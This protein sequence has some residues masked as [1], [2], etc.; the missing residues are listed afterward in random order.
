M[1]AGKLDRRIT[2][3]SVTWVK[4]EFGDDIEVE[5]PLATIWAFLMEQRPGEV[6]S[7]GSDQSTDQVIFQIRK[8]SD[9]NATM[10]VEY[11]T[12]RFEITGI[13]EVGRNNRLNLICERQGE[14]V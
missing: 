12:D 8:R 1:R 11:K 7:A 10:I 3:I 4:N 9:I 6:F 5:T 2:V 13:K 14:N